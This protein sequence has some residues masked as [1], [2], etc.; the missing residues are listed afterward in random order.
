MNTISTLESIAPIDSKSH[1]DHY[2][3]QTFGKECDYSSLSDKN[4]DRLALFAKTIEEPVVIGKFN[5]DEHYIETLKLTLHSTLETNNRILFFQNT[6]LPIIY[7][8]N[9][10]LDIGPGDGSITN[11]IAPYFKKITA[12]DPNYCTLENLDILISDPENF[13]KINKDIILTELEDNTYDLAICSHVLYYIDPEQ[14]LNLIQNIYNSLKKN[15]LLAIVL[16]GDELGKANLIES[17]GGVNLKIDHLASECQNLFGLN[18][19]YLYASNEAFITSSKE[20]M[21]HISAF[22]LADANVSAKR[23][24]LIDYITQNFQLSE[25]RFLMTTRQKFIVIKKR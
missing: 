20:A 14:R 9:S 3:Y 17:F 22:M 6:I 11:Q 5:N 1:I 23:D 15:G 13:I 16:G 12:V 24:D 25:N 2:R 7:T 8:K 4:L 10:M 21:F 18:N 19:V